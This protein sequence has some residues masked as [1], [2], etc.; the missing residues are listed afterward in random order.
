MITHL[1]IA[2]RCW[3]ITHICV[4]PVIQVL[5]YLQVHR[6]PSM[7]I[8]PQVTDGLL[9]KSQTESR[10]GFNP[11]CIVKAVVLTANNSSTAMCPPPSKNMPM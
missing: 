5:Q 3:M 4:N 8:V 9:F 7:L 6:L 10:A 2:L 11:R 1:Y